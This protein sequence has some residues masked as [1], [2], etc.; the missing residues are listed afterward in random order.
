[1]ALPCINNLIWFQK[2]F[3]RWSVF[4]R[5]FDEN[6]GEEDEAPD[7]SFNFEMVKSLENKPGEGR[8][9]T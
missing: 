4:C 8:I 9:S 1:M 5:R 6:R 3:R 7:G 2:V